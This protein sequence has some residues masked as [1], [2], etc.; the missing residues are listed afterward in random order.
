LNSHRLVLAL[1]FIGLVAGIISGLATKLVATPEHDEFA[2]FG[3]A[4]YW[5]GLHSASGLSFN[6]VNYSVTYTERPPLVWWLMTSLFSLGASPY[7]ALLISPVFTSLNAILIALFAYEL[8]EELKYG[9]IAGLL[10]GTSGFAASI[11]AHILS[12]AMGTFFAVLALFSFYEYFF[13]DRRFF[14]PLL[15]ASVGLGLVARDEDLITL[16]L[17]IILWIVFVPK[18][19]TM[20]RLLYLLTFGLLFGIPIKIL[21]LIGTMQLLSNLATPLIF[22]GWPF[23]LFIGALVTYLAIRSKT[24]SRIAELGAAVFAFFVAMLP[25]F[26]DNYTLGNVDYFIAGKGVLARPVSHLMMIPQTGGV[27]AGLN[28]SVRAYEWLSSIPSLLSAPV[29]IFA[30]LGIY[31]S[32]RNNNKKNFLFLAIWA[33]VSFGYVVGTTNLEDRFLL[34]AFAPTVIFAGMGLG[35]VWRKNNLLGAILASASFALGDMIPRS[36]ISISNLTVVAEITR[37]SENWLYSFLPSLSLSSPK[38]ILPPSLLAEGFV[39]LPFALIAVSIGA[40]FAI[41]KRPFPMLEI[42]NTLKEPIASPIPQERIPDTRISD[43][44]SSLEKKEEEEET[45]LIEDKVTLTPENPGRHHSTNR[46]TPLREPS[47]IQDG[48]TFE[49]ELGWLF[50]NNKS[51]KEIKWKKVGKDTVVDE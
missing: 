8:T 9:V 31:Y 25:F 12:D 28:L 37:N 16:V 18:I 45:E 6:G 46:N 5:S 30:A 7:A 43:L 19:T 48:A 26:F 27:G 29:L 47:M 17:L 51:S 15:G 20:K 14:A 22:G 41:V 10:A 38:S 44:D 50:S 39:S 13:K 4:L 21:G 42:E 33:L 23:F 24:R 3:N 36:A 49:E 34:I 35:Y 2:Y 32:A 11:G 40:Y 1:L